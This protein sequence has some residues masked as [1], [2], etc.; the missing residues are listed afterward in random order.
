MEHI[1]Y[2][3][4]KQ[5]LVK[6]DLQNNIFEIHKEG[7]EGESL[8]A[9]IQVS[10]GANQKEGHIWFSY[11]LDQD[12]I[13]LLSEAEISVPKEFT[14]GVCER[15]E[16]CIF[17]LSFAIEDIEEIIAL[18]LSQLLDVFY[19]KPNQT[20]QIDVEGL[21]SDNGPFDHTLAN[22]YRD[23]GIFHL[24]SDAFSEPGKIKRLKSAVNTELFKNIKLLK[25]KIAAVYNDDKYNEW[26]DYLLANREKAI[27]SLPLLKERFYRLCEF[28]SEHF[29]DCLDPNYGDLEWE[30]LAIKNHFDNWSIPEYIE[31]VNHYRSTMKR[32][33]AYEYLDKRLDD[34][35]QVI[36]KVH[37]VPG[38]DRAKLYSLLKLNGRSYGSIITSVLVAN[39]VIREEKVR[40][41]RILYPVN[42]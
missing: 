17:D 12:I 14:L 21:G 38:I 34:L 23:A 13:Q 3:K 18:F 4:I 42:K 32:P 6:H 7:K 36:Q 33:G 31:M 28:Y 29:F 16:Y 10:P 11:S 26:D 15:G 40:S 27:D 39:N 5:S 37:E 30:Y 19:G 2:N 24:D 20:I 9:S 1:H 8:E 22:L 25:E 35:K 41:K